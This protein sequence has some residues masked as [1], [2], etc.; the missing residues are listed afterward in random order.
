MSKTAIRKEL[1][2][3]IE[4][5]IKLLEASNWKLFRTLVKNLSRKVWKFSIRHKSF[6]LGA[7]LGAV[8][9]SVL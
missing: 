1:D 4:A 6:I 8:L 5:K 7:V 9:R 3:E 2:Q